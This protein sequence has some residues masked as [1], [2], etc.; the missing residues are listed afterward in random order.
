MTPKQAQ[1]M[2]NEL[3][4]VYATYPNAFIYEIEARGWETLNLGGFFYP[5]SN[6]RGN[7]VLQE[8]N[9]F[10]ATVPMTPTSGTIINAQQYNR[11]G[12]EYQ[13]VIIKLDIF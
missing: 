12:S 7:N 6:A 9:R 4:Q 1:K 2:T 11:S 3:Q 13:K 10:E 8:L 5:L